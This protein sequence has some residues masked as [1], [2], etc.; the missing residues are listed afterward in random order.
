MRFWQQPPYFGI[1]D[2]D[3]GW[4]VSLLDRLCDM[5]SMELEE[6]LADRVAKSGVRFHAINWSAKNI[7]ISKSDINWL[8]E[9]GTDEY[10]FVQF[11]ISKAL[12]RVVGFFD[13]ENTFQIVLLDPLHNIQPSKDYA[14]RIRATQVASCELSRLSIRYESA[15]TSAM[16]LTQPQKDG[17][18]E[19][20][21]AINVDGFDAA[22]LLTIEDAK[23]SKAYELC[24]TGAV[25]NLGELLQLAIE[26]T[27]EKYI[28][29]A[30][31]A[32]S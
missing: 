25:K 32:V 26:E 14:Y 3:S 27:H 8:G 12:G 29:G 4:F 10:E 30:N 13:E 17:L 18:L 5:S 28:A 19:Q 20:V 11:H 6:F 2:C 16:T 21:R 1:S 15:V 24:A 9:Y 22:V 23:L 31:S 7:P